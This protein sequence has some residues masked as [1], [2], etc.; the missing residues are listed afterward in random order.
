MI[1]FNSA[2]SRIWS[3]YNV[4]QCLLRIQLHI[5]LLKNINALIQHK[6]IN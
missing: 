1:K 3:K 4:I 6:A 2:V 5:M